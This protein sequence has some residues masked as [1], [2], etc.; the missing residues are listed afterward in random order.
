M[1]N[2]GFFWWAGVVL[3]AIVSVTAAPVAGQP[4]PQPGGEVSIEQAI[5]DEAQMKTIAFDGLAFLTGDLCSDTFF[6]P[7][8]VS[9][10]F[11]FQYMRDIAPNGFGHNTEFAGRVAD[12]VLSI[13]T[14]A[15]VQALVTLANTQAAQVDAYGY[16]RFVLMKAFR[17]LLE[18]DL[19]D[20]STGLNKSAVMEFSAD[21]YEIDGEI[22]YARAT[23][24]GG[25]LAEFTDAQ[26]MALAELEEEFNA[27]FEEAGEGGVIANEDWPAAT[28][29]DLSGLEVENGRVLV[30]TY[31][32]QLYSWYL[33]SV[34][35]DTYFCPERHGTYFGSFYM[36][37]IPPFTASEPVTIDEGVTAEMGTAFLN[38][39]DNTQAVLVTGL[40]D[41]QR[42]ALHNIVSVR[43]EISRKLRPFMDGDPVERNE[44]LSLVRQYGEY[45]GEIVYNYATNFRAVGNTLTDAQEETLLGLR[46]D[47]Y[48]RF[49]AYQENPDAYDC[50]GAWLYSS[51]IEMPEIE[52]TDFL[53]LGFGD[54]YVLDSGDYDGDGTD[55][56][57]VFRESSGLWAVRGLTRTYFGTVG[58]APAP[59]DY[60][61]DG[62]TDIAVFRVTNGLW[63]ARGVTRAYFGAPSDVA[64]PLR[65]NPSAACSIGVFRPSTGLWAVRGVTR[66]YFGT[67]G[68]RP[69]PGDYDGDGTKEIGIFR[70]SSGLWAMKG[71]SRFYFGA[72]GD[73][74]LPC[75]Y[76]GD[77]TCEAGI[78]RPAS[79]LWAIRG[80]TR[81]YFGASSDRL[82]PADYDGDWTDDAGIFRDSSGLWAVRGLTRVYYGTSG[83]TP[84]TR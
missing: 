64:V 9:D 82:V 43:E 14:D 10:F 5:S 78:F 48:E 4:A 72:S 44:A 84:V 71:V 39:L 65:M 2:K 81:M 80:V 17:R 7:G 28:P 41:T 70:E 6:P 29:V 20:G 75:D 27:L 47:Y 13:L 26:R 45:D 60:D 12:S 69:I 11:G 66:A 54:D 37:D 24:I 32:G 76:D 34:E 55:D 15:Q 33:G 62:T 30:S 16:N 49:P 63:A 68:D 61:G 8:K 40:V 58:D 59:G 23:V 42:T 83:D 53:F 67:S 18:N 35:G 31:A 3:G 36:K 74:A 46:I 57:G 50:S 73:E 1:E 22:S 51:R 38:A 25:I 21:L 19:P 52:N 79:S 77:G 56:I